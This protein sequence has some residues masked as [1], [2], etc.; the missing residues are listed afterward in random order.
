VREIPEWLW[1]VAVCPDDRGALRPADGGAVCATCGTVYAGDGGVLDLLPSRLREPDAKDPA[2]A[3]IQEEMRWWNPWYEGLPRRPYSPDA[4]LRGRSR[5]L[6]LFGP[7]RDRLP[8][9]PL[10]LEMG[11]G[12]SR[13]V[14][15]LWPPARDGLRYAAT[16]MS[17]PALR[18]GRELL[19]PTA[20]SVRC[21]AVD[22]PFR[23]GVADVVLILGVLHHLSDWR[24]AL[25]RA[26]ASVRPGGFLLLHEAVTKP[27]V[28]ARFRAHGVDDHW[29]SP[30]EGDVPAGALRTA[31]EG[32]GRLIRWHAELSPLGFGL[33]RYGIERF[34]LEQRLES[35]P[36]LATAL[37]AA[38]QAFGRTAGRVAPSLG[39]NEVSAVWQRDGQ[40]EVGR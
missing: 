19:G 7:V 39:F 37:S 15:G 23:E 9:Q 30:H 28:L 33:I 13:T 10:V 14:A 2:A 35:S 12:D 5:E 40:R 24:Q 38:D 18:A 31:L 8:A 6:N 16:D 22:W 25:E 11:A 26:C 3:W 32:S 4:G 36:A 1:D 29:V 20:A 27:R 21:D 34:G 17:P